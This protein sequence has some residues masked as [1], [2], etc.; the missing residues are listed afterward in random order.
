MRLDSR[1]IIINDKLGES[2][3]DDYMYIE[4]RQM[5]RE[6]YILMGRKICFKYVKKYLNYF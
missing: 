3:V 4:F 6:E 1:D 2:F 5:E